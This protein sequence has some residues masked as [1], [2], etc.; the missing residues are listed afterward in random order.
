LV[1]LSLL[2]VILWTFRRN[3]RD[4]INLYNSLSPVMQLASGGN[5]LNFGYWNGGAE[6]PVAAQ[7]RICALVGDAA[8]LCSAKRLIDIGSGLSAPG[9]LWKSMHSSIDI[10]CVN[11]N[12][13]QLSFAS[14]SVC[15][16]GS[17][18]LVNAT[19]TALPFSDQSADRIVALESAQH[20]RPLEKFV[21]EARRILVPGGVLVMALPVTTARARGLQAFKL[22]ILSFTWSSEHYGLDYVK[23]A[24]ASN[25]FTIKDVTH[26]GSYV[27]RP[28]T[29]Y[30][31]LNRK[32]LRQKI[33]QEYPSF[34]EGVLYKSLLK[35]KD[36]SAKGIIDYVIIKAS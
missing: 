2:Q 11:I 7:S 19:S 31:V 17:V 25:G 4:V 34:L 20:F 12:Y 14:K 10:S 3:E 8:E 18:S 35:M 30:Y 33:L 15:S 1:S 27:Y 32:S 29:D 21:R 16:P 36:V 28:L 23:S 13:R 5:M 6:N 22:G 9:A 24:I 26:I